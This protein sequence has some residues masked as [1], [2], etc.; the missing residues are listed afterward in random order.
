M[1]TAPVLRHGV[2]IALRRTLELCMVERS[3]PGVHLLRLNTL[4][5]LA[6][7]AVTAFLIVSLLSPTEQG[8]WYT[9]ASLGLLTALVELGFSDMLAQRVSALYARVHF[10]DGTIDGAPQDVD[11]LIALIRQAL[12]FY[13]LVVVAVWVLLVSIGSFLF[14][15]EPPEVLVVFFLYA[16]VK[17]LNLLA[18]LLQAIYQ[19]FD[20]VA[21]AQA[22]VLR[23]AVCLGVATIAA[24]WFGLRIWAIVIGNSVGVVVLLV[25][26]Y[27]GAPRLCAQIAKFGLARGTHWPLSLLPVQFRYGANAIAA[28]FAFN[29]FVPAVYRLEG[30]VAAGQLGLTLSIIGAASSLSTAFAR[31][32]APSF[33]ILVATGRRVELEKLMREARVRLCTS[34]AIVAMAVLGGLLLLRLNGTYDDRLLNPRLVAL[35]LMSY[36]VIILITP[37][38]YYLRAHGD[39]PWWV[40]SGAYALMICAAIAIVLP[41]YGLPGL[42]LAVSVI[43]WCA[44]LPLGALVFWH[45]KAKYEAELVSLP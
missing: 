21:E 33:S 26:L 13:L 41:R 17:A 19:G 9:F 39:E 20:R 1:R 18:T 11:N 45:F 6:R 40:V 4:V 35:M 29:L 5:A 14:A 12:R 44:L 34:Y 38:T 28:Y 10:R 23:S 22:T 24:L 25:S 37:W 15:A 32:K 8:L 31:A 2:A 30:P 42:L 27:H 7:E 36:L 16:M 43:N 3:L